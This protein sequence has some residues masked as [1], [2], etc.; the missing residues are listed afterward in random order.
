[1]HA[2]HP[3]SARTKVSSKTEPQ[4]GGGGVWRQATRRHAKGTVPLLKERTS[5]LLHKTVVR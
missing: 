1:M 2:S 5:L 4:S 3:C